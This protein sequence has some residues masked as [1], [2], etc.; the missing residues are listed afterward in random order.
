MI[1]NKRVFVANYLKLLEKTGFT[2]IRSIQRNQARALLLSAIT[3]DV[4]VAMMV[5]DG[6][7]PN[8][9]QWEKVSAVWEYCDFGARPAFSLEEQVSNSFL[10]SDETLFYW[11]KNAGWEL[12]AYR[13]IDGVSEMVG[14]PL[15]FSDFE[16]FMLKKT[17]I[18]QVSTVSPLIAK[19]C[20]YFFLEEEKKEILE[21]TE[22]KEQEE[23]ARREKEKRKEEREKAIQEWKR[24]APA[25]LFYRKGDTPTDICQKAAVAFGR[26]TNELESCENL[27]A[28]YDVLKKINY[29]LWAAF[30]AM[31][32]HC[33]EVA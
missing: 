26:F 13:L 8:K 7:K 10:I 2:S 19:Y 12:L 11:L 22:R 3:D 25:A 27:P 29:A 33:P 28:C 20:G 15:C 24:A 21:I 31:E 14:R 18:I 4:K 9:G 32:K 5:F 30:K 1:Y 23:E 6:I 17:E 16:G